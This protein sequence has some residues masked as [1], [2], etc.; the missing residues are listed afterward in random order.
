MNSTQKK[1]VFLAVVFI[2]IPFLL[3]LR[4]V[5][6]RKSNLEVYNDL[7]QEPEKN[8]TKLA[9]DSNYKPIAE[10]QTS[11]GVTGGSAGIGMD[12]IITEMPTRG[13]CPD[14][15]IPAPNDAGCIVPGYKKPEETIYP[16]LIDLKYGY[17]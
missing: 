5:N 4:I 2:L 11:T 12:V 3:S 1:Y 17:E 16:D 14:G 6:L 9:D 13:N 7:M 15:M 8:D 10:N